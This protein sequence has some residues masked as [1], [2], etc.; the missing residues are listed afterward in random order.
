MVDF[1]ELGEQDYELVE[2]VRTN[3]TKFQEIENSKL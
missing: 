1:T 3:K 2:V